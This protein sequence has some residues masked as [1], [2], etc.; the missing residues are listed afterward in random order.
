M[1]IGHRS[2]G[3]NDRFEEVLRFFGTGLSLRRSG[4]LG[5]VIVLLLVVLMIVLRLGLGQGLGKLALAAF[6]V[7]SN[8][9]VLRGARGGTVHTMRTTCLVS[10]N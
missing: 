1:T 3:A 2:K 8:T 10:R 4:L 5:F 7:N 9:I 6:Y